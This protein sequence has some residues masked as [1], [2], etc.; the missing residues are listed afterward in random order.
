MLFMIK[1]FSFFPLSRPLA[2][3]LPPLGFFF[4]FRNIVENL[5]LLPASPFVFLAFFL[6]LT[7]F[8]FRI[9]LFF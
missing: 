2:P 5:S 8:P 4:F 1:F 9:G 7:F 6:F 3:L